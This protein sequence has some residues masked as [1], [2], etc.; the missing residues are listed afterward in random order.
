MR[1]VLDEVKLNLWGKSSLNRC[2]VQILLSAAPNVKI[3][4]SARRLL[5]HDNGARA[6]FQGSNRRHQPG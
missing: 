5:E 3:I 2:A 1:M 4:E 6:L